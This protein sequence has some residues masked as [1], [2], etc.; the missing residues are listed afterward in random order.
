MDYY[1]DV[2]YIANEG[3]DEAH[4]VVITF[5]TVTKEAEDAVAKASDEYS[6]Y[7]GMTHRKATIARYGRMFFAWF[8]ING[9]SVR[10]KRA[11]G[12]DEIAMRYAGFLASA[13]LKAYEDALRDGKSGVAALEAAEDEAYNVDVAFTHHMLGYVR[14]MMEELDEL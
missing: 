13:S 14:G 1:K 7:I 5:D 11:F 6:E 12:D 4:A 9:C 3:T 2:E 8:S 10:A